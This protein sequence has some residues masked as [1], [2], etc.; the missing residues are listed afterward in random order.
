MLLK[1]MQSLFLALFFFCGVSS[2][3][4]EG[5][6]KVSLGL[7]V[8]VGTSEYRD[9]DARV[10]PIPL[11]NYEGSR[12]Y[13][14]GL[15]AGLYLFKNQNHAIS[16]D[17]NYLP[18]YFD[19]SKSDNWSMKQ[20]SDRKSSLMAG[21]SYRFSSQYGIA[22][23]G[24]ACDILGK[25]DGVLV[26]ASYAYPIHFDRLVLTPHLGVVWASSDY[27][28]YYYG[29]SRGESLRSGLT[30]YNADSGFSPYAGLSANFSLTEQWGLFL[31][32]GS[33]YLSSEVRDS[34][35]VSRDFKHS[36]GAGVV[37]NF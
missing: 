6:H 36:L 17:L 37:Y 23:L 30:A 21:A 27:N 33:S 8:G 19:A 14:R 11:I 22:S 4:A 26:N 3:L 15:G 16:L 29:V 18:H 28:D 13:A 7:G 9:M 24:A 5:E 31:N 12:F 20:L 32:A 10:L 35:M 2:A 34:P 1:T 25:S